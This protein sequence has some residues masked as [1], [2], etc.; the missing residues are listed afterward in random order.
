[1]PI[2]NEKGDISAWHWMWWVLAGVVFLVV[3]GWG[4]T[5]ATFGLRVATAGIVGAGEARIEIKSADF[6]LAAYPHFFDLCAAV[7]GHEFGIDAQYAV[8]ESLDPD[9]GRTRR[10]T[11]TNIAGLETA[12]G[13]DVSQY[14]QDAN[15]S[16]TIGQFRDSDL[17]YQLPTQ[18]YSP[19]GVK[20][21]CALQ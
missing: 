20:T 7:Q 11:L 9:D 5:A 12:W 1:M 8:L 15:K 16:W 21:Q 6:R 17:P 13:R 4:L 18:P 2:I 3:V 14:N 19:E 10:I